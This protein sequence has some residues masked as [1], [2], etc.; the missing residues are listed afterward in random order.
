MSTK[1]SLFGDILCRRT[2]DYYDV[3]CKPCEE[4]RLIDFVRV[5]RRTVDD[6]MKNPYIGKTWYDEGRNHRVENGMIARD[7]DDQRWV[8]HIENGD[9]LQ[10]FIE[11]Y[12]RI[13][14][15]L[16]RDGLEPRCEIEI[17]DTYRE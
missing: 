8:V 1:P 16:D 12:G 5:D 4:A 15:A 2:S 9:A 13:V 7:F 11:K 14:I 17:Y 3:D 6:P 10:K